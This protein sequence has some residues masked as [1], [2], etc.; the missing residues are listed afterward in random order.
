[1]FH[2]RCFLLHKNV[3]CPLVTKDSVPLP[4]CVQE[5][6]QKG[7]LLRNTVTWTPNNL[8]LNIC[9]IYVNRNTNW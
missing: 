6:K 5:T 1:M 7:I 4:K 2:E 3:V 8:T 9:K